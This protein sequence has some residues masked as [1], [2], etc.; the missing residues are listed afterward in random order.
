M[1]THRTFD[2]IDDLAEYLNGLAAQVK[3][4]EQE[5]AFHV[6][7]LEDL[8]KADGVDLT[9]LPTWGPCPYPNGNCPLGVFSWDSTGTPAWVLL[10]TPGYADRQPWTVD[11]LEEEDAR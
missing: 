6:P 7:A 8:C 10:P 9:D 4:A 1:S 2:S 5:E 3:H 11:T